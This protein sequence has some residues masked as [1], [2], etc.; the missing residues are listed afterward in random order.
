MSEAKKE[1]IGQTKGLVSAFKKLK[2][3]D[4]A[5]IEYALFAKDVSDLFAAIGTFFEQQEVKEHQKRVVRNA[6]VKIEAAITERKRLT[7]RLNNLLEELE[8][9]EM[10]AAN[11]SAK[12]MELEEKEKRL[13]DI[14][15]FRAKYQEED[16]ERLSEELSNEEESIADSIKKVE[17]FSDEILA[18]IQSITDNYGLRATEILKQ[19]DENRDIV[20]GKSEGM[21]TKLEKENVLLKLATEKSKK[22][23][24]QLLDD[25]NQTRDT[26]IRIKEQIREVEVAHTQNLALHMRHFAANEEVFGKL[27]EQVNVSAA[28]TSLLNEIKAKLEEFDQVLGQ[29][30]RENDSIQYVTVSNSNAT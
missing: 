30:I 13:K 21:V 19:I 4:L 12:Q 1:I 11:T 28:A 2:A 24:A 14:Q 9:Q 3:T 25:Y 15:T 17:L 7:E 27:K 22:A 6:S 5:T 16:L 29:V 20:Q 8:R 18:L 26:I 23:L 10:E